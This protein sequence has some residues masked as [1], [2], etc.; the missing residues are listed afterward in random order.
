MITGMLRKRKRKNGKGSYEK[1]LF[2]HFNL[3]PSKAL[4]TLYCARVFSLD[5]PQLDISLGILLSRKIVNLVRITTKSE[6]FLFA[7]M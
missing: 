3:Q 5:C 1:Q 2:P 4:D 6:Y 7:K